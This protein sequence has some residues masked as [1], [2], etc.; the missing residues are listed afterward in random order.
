MKEDNPSNPQQFGKN[1]VHD[2]PNP[3]SG[4]FG[5]DCL[6]PKRREDENLII[7]SE[8]LVRLRRKQRTALLTNP[9][10]K[11]PRNPS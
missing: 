1:E 5:D 11:I 8:A 2:S 4:V 10:R 6:V 7:D 3:R 9:F